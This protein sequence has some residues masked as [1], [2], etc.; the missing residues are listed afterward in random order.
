MYKLKTNSFRNVSQLNIYDENYMTILEDMNWQL[1]NEVL[2]YM[3][4][5]LC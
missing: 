3:T 4:R 5:F 2:P 1:V